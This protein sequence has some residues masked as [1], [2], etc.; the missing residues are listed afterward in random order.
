MQKIRE[1]YHAPAAMVGD[2]INDAPVLAAG[3]LGI[4]IGSGSNIALE[5]AGVILPGNNLKAVV[6]L[7]RLSRAAFRVIR[8]NL[9]W[10][11]FYNFCA[12]PVAAGITYVFWGIRFNPAVCAGMMAA[13]SL[14][15]VLNSLR[16]LAWKK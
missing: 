16:L 13:S 6:Q 8:Q 5:S 9:F 7:I 12:I 2:G 11:F 3:D 4:A 14:C 1:E 15:V 10:A